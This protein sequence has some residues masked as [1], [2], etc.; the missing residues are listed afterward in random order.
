MTLPRKLT[1]KIARRAVVLIREYGHMRGW[2]ST[3]TVKPLA[4]KDIVGVKLNGA[5]WLKYQS[6]GTH[7]FIPWGLEG[8]TVPMKWKGITIFRK[9][10]GVGYP[11]F[12]HQM[13]SDVLLWRSQKWRN[14]GVKPTHFIDEAIASA[15]KMFSPQVEAAN[16]GRVWKRDSR[17]RDHV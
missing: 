16:G 9:A 6:D 14:P 5:Y 15:F 10:V 11:G 8:K 7:P 17:R 3:A 1:E 2:K 12:V 4:R 13:E